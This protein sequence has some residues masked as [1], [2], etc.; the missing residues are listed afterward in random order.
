MSNQVIE[1]FRL[2]PQ[3]EHLWRL[4]QAA[5]HSPYRAQC[6]VRIEGR[7]DAGK[8]RAAIEDVVRRH[9]ILRTTFPRPVSM[10]TSLQTVGETAGFSF[11]HG[12]LNEQTHAIDK[13]YEE[14][15]CEPF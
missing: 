10:M 14:F 8:L 5:H 11:Q 2:S 13:L 12:E 3:Q 6:A 4:E 7:L 9:E 1:G 15:G